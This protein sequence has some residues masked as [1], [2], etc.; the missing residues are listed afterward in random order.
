MILIMNFQKKLLYKSFIFCII[1]LFT[2]LKN[3]VYPAIESGSN[4]KIADIPLTEIKSASGKNKTL[5]ILISGDAGWTWMHKKIAK[6]LSRNDISIVGLNS[7]KYFWKRRAPEEA[8]QDFGRV[9]QYYKNKWK[10]KQTILA[11]YSFGADVLPFIAARLP[12]DIKEDI[13]SIVLIGAE[14][15]TDFKIHISSWFEKSEGTYPVL[16]E[17]LKLN[18][19]KVLCVCGEKE[20]NSI[21]NKIKKGEAR[22]RILK[23]GH[24]FN[25]NYKALAGIIKEESENS[26]ENVNE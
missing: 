23:G 22:I 14:P 7:L 9:I 25:W 5:V 1:I 2:V 18:K 8:A 16:P 10:V 20:N 11:G 24:H 19:I 26:P 15:Y 12:G 13:R 17:V 4:N 21:C 6:I 3:S